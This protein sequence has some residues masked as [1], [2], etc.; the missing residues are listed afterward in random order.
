MD[1]KSDANCK[2]EILDIIKSLKANGS[3]DQFRKDCFAEILTQVTYSYMF[4]FLLKIY[5]IFNLHLQKQTF[6]NLKKTVEE[7][8]VN[9]LNDLK[10]NSQTK[11]TVL[12]DNVRRLLLE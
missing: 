9:Y 2:T 6:Q 10:P 5:I 7:F 8:V 3:F 4:I 1:L 12:R 11:K